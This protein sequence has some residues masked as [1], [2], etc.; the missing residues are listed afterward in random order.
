[1]T[2]HEILS[3]VKTGIDLFLDKTYEMEDL[4]NHFLQIIKEHSMD[5]KGH[6]EKMERLM[7]KVDE[8]REAQRLYWGG[9]KK[10]IGQC[11]VLEKDLD[12]KI[13]YLQ[14]HGG[15]SIDRFKQEK[16]KQGSLI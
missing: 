16:P 13:L 15:Y 5:A 11:K 6:K 2:E 3:R 10:K 8:L 4:Y 12:N 7:F 9:D 14:T 1:M